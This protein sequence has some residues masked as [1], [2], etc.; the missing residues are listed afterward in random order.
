MARP[1]APAAPALPHQ[2]V[3]FAHNAERELA[4][5]LD[6]FGVAWEYEP[7]TFVLARS[8][9]GQPTL[10]FTPD[11]YLPAHDLYVEVTTLNQKLVTR[12]NRKLRL[13]RQQ[14]PEVAVRLIYQRDYLALRVRYG[15]AP[16]SQLGEPPYRRRRIRARA[17]EDLGL[18]GL[19]SL[20]VP[21]GSARRRAG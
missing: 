6:A 16:P 10:A 14:Y 9:D 8:A 2:G 12:K 3:E 4:E 18:L 11:F 19:G 7:R 13:L 20:P 21:A 5:L 17:D 15:L 1:V